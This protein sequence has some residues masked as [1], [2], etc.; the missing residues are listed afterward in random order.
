MAGFGTFL[1]N[2]MTAIGNAGATHSAEQANNFQSSAYRPTSYQPIDIGFKSGADAANEIG[3]NHKMTLILA[4]ETPIPLVQ[5]TADKNAF[6]E[7]V[8]SLTCEY[9]T[10]DIKGALDLAAD[11]LNQNKGAEVIVYTDKSYLDTDGITVIDCKKETDWNAGIV[12][13]EDNLVETKDHITGEIGKGYEFVVNVGNYGM[14]STFTVEL[15]VDNN[16][17]AS[18]EVTLNPG[19]VKQVRFYPSNMVKY[20]DKES[21]SNSLEKYRASFSLDSQLYKSA[22]VK[23]R[24]K[25]TDSFEYDDSMTIYPKYKNEDIK[26]LYVSEYV[27]VEGGKKHANNSVLNF[28]LKAKGY[29]V[30]PE[31]MFN[32]IDDVKE[33][34]GYDIYIFEGVTPYYL[35]TDGAVWLINVDNIDT[36]MSEQ[37]GKKTFVAESG[38]SIGQ[39]MPEFREGYVIEKAYGENAVSELMENVYI[40]IPLQY[41]D[42][43]YPAAVYTYSKIT[44]G[45]SFRPVY[46]TKNAQGENEDL[47]VAGSFR[48]VPM[49]IASFDFKNSSLIAYISDFPMLVKNMISYSV[50]EPI[51]LRAANIGEKIEF[52]FPVGAIDINIKYKVSATAPDKDDIVVATYNISDYIE[53]LYEEMEKGE[54]FVIEDRLVASFDVDKPG[55]Y[56]IEI[57]FPDGDDADN[58]LDMKKYSITGRISPEETSITQH[59]VTDSLV[60]PE[61]LPTADYEYERVEIFPYVIGLFIILL[62]IEWGVY[63]REQ[64]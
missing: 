61:L 46:T 40:D 60:Y 3:D 8:N 29:T 34:K 52:K 36:I 48:T 26:I 37:G 45:N 41:L 43:E 58:L 14:G 22:T 44:R 15:F 21:D 56:Y 2:I 63:Y 4:G 12:F 53:S 17:A 30:S 24:S 20:D 18:K 13:F 47:F 33:L 42:K 16:M 51:D 1:G 54:K 35:P 57:K 5:R 49:I 9:S 27:V 10:S 32:N 6:M 19:E 59:V 7:A 28:A 62:I 11:Y 50:T 23:I 64:Y 55:M 39:P 25:M 31:N 38:V